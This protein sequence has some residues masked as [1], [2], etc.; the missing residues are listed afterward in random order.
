MPLNRQVFCIMK[1]TVVDVVLCTSHDR[2]KHSKWQLCTLPFCVAEKKLIKFMR[3]AVR[4][5]WLIWNSSGKCQHSAVKESL[6]VCRMG[7]SVHIQPE[8][9]VRKSRQSAMWNGSTPVTF[10]FHLELHP[11]WFALSLLLLLL[12][13]HVLSELYDFIVR[14]CL[15]RVG[16]LCSN[17]S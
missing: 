1:T 17:L 13:E 15:S 14:V 6:F 16:I 5:Q 12:L 8:G 3:F 4:M 7:L 2:N 10:T 11:T 9:F